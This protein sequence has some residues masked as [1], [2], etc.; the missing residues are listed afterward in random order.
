[1]LLEMSGMPADKICW[2]ESP[3]P[4]SGPEGGFSERELQLI[5]KHK[6]V[7]PLSLGKTRLR[8]KTAPIVA[9]GALTARG[10]RS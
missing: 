9:L 2:K 4:L 7:I 5:L 6:S 1:M 3:W 8:A 10:D